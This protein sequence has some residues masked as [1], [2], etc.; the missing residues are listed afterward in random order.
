MLTI[1]EAI[2]SAAEYLDKK[3]VKSA[4]LNAELLLAHVLNC[5]RMQ[6]YLS[7]DSPLKKDEIDLY[8]ELLLRRSKYEPLQYILGKV[9]FFGIEL[10]VNSSVL[11]PRPE[12]E[13]LVEEIIH[14]ISKEKEINILEVGC[15]CGNIAIALASNI[16]NSKITAIDVSESAILLSE[17]NAE[18]N[19]VLNKITFL[20]QD[21]FNALPKNLGDYDLI[22]SNPPY[23]SLEDFN[24]LEPELRLYEPQIALTDGLDGLTFYKRISEQSKFLLK[25]KGKIFFEIGIGQ[26]DDVNKIL[27]DSGFDNIKIKKD[28]SG[29]DRIIS[30]ELI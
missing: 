15:G 11:I 7:Y 12:T 21:I 16:S 14:S 26:S 19:G 29:I 25:Q 27:V 1:L 28:Y 18:M 30:G 13:L 10:K 22:V 6:L 3:N 23:V 5:K 4:R 20:K 8:R 24:N 2:N 9:E 17:E